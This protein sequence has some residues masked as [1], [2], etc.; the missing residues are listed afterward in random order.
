MQFEVN[1]TGI[2]MS[3]EQIGR[4]FLP[5]EQ[6]DSSI[7]RVYGGSGLGLTISQRL[8]T[9][10]GG[11]ITAQS[12]LGEGSTFTLTISAMRPDAPED[13]AELDLGELPESAAPTA[14]TGSTSRI[15]KRPL[16]VRTLIVDDR[17]DLRLLSQRFIEKFGGSVLI[18]EDGGQALEI[19]EREAAAGREIDLV[20]MDLQMPKM[21]G[22]TTTKM[23]RAKGFRNPIIALTANAMESDRQHCLE[24]GFTDFL[25]KPI[26]SH[27]LYRMLRRYGRTR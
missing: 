27:E 14:P 11:E 15:D 17:R 16:D 4:L 26:D 24:S 1:D 6:A 22:I 18:A 3:P 7:R 21:D 9:L 13:T 8:A 23:L 19:I 5:F 25:S 12:R 10:L 2:G 20:L